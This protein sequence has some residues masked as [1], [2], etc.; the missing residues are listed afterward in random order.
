MAGGDAWPRKAVPLGERSKHKNEVTY[1]AKS[2][3]EN[4]ERGL[5]L[6]K[7]PG[8]GVPVFSTTD[9]SPPRIEK[10]TKINDSLHC[11]YRIAVWSSRADRG[12]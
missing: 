6:S 10:S 2:Q 9:V 8:K 1:V 4:D 7:N 12:L 5:S 11:Q 3:N